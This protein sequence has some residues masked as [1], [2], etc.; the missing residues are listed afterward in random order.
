MTKIK[1]I[2]IISPN[3]LESIG[4]KFLLSEYFSIS[5]VILITDYDSFSSLD[6]DELPDLIF[7]SPEIYVLHEYFQGIK[8]KA[9]IMINGN[10]NVISNQPK[11]SYINIGLSESEIIDM[12]GQLLEAHKKQSNNYE[13]SEE[14]STRE[15]EVLKF[16]ARGLMSKQ[17]ADIL[18]ISLHTVISHR[19]NITRK[20]GINTVSGL[21]IYALLNG[22]I[23]PNEVE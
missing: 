14:L 23:S 13:A 5:E 3:C 7:L 10:D 2:A 1:H 4:L 8:N 12:L 11:L 15:I 6:C 16:V 21:S 18:S 22:L 9:V 17:I 20:L 19:K